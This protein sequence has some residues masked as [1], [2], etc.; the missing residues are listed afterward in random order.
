MTAW[1]RLLVMA[2][3]A[4]LLAG[5]TA[6][7]VDYHTGRPGTVR[8]SPASGLCELY[9][10]GSP[11]LARTIIKGEPIGFEKT[12]GGLVAVAGPYQVFLRDGNY[13]WQIVP[14]PGENPEVRD[15]A[16]VGALFLLGISLELF[17][18]LWFFRHA[19]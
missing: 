6:D 7:T 9:C 15:P 5:C 10:N 14:A 8:P 17:R 2:G 1:N 11:S 16:L 3:C 18:W 4:A 12:N 19:H 13:R